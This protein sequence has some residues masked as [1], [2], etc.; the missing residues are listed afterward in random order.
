[1]LAS[2][3]AL[4]GLPGA[5]PLG[6][7]GRG[8]GG[9]GWP[10][11]RSRA[12]PLPGADPVPGFQQPGVESGRTDRNGTG[13]GNGH[14]DTNAPPRLSPSVPPPGRRGDLGRPPGWKGVVEGT[15]PPTPAP[16]VTRPPTPASQAVQTATLNTSSTVVTPSATCRQP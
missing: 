16:G 10:P 4:V 3:F 15:P 2:S 12:R 13:S 8:G 9:E 6:Q 14:V 1:A 5:F 7:G 11:A